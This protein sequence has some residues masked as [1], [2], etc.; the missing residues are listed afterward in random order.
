MAMT[1]PSCGTEQP[2]GARFCFAC[3]AAQGAA[4]CP[5]CGTELVPGARFC[6]G[7]GAVQ[8]S[9]AAGLSG[10]APVASRR[11]TSVLFGDLVG[12]TTLAERRDQEETRELL[13]RYFEECRRVIT[14]YGGTVEKFIGDAVMAV[15]GVPVAHEDDAERAV[16]AGLELVAVVT[17]MGEDLHIDDLSM[18]VG[19]VT[20]EVAVTIGAQQQGMVAGD[21]VNTASR[22]QSVAAPGQVWVDETTRLLTTSAI[23]YLDVGSHRLKGKADPVPLGS[24]RAVVAGVGGSQREDGLEAPLVGREHELR[25]VKEVF[26]ATDEA[27]RPKLLVMVGEP[28]V[29]KTRLAWEFEKYVDGLTMTVRWH[30]GRCVAY[31]EGI[32]FF[33]LAEAIR[34]RLRVL[35]PEDADDDPDPV[36]GIETALHSYVPD[37]EERDWLRPRLGALLGV[38]SL[39]TFPREDL[40]AAWTT[41]LER[42]GEGEDPV[43]LVIDDVHHAHDGLLQFVEHLLD[44]GR[45]PCFVLLLSRPGLLERH[46]ALATNRHATVSHVHALPDTDMA[47]LLDGLVVGLPD[48]VRDALVDRSE[49]VPLFAVET[50]RSL[51][52]RDLVVPRGGRYVLADPSSVDLDAVGAPASLQALVGARLDA[53]APEH[54]R[55]VDRASVI[56]TVFSRDEVAKLCPDIDDVDAALAALVRQQILSQQSSRFNAEYGQYQ[57]VQSVVRQVA[58]G[59]LSRRDRRALHVAVARQTAAVEDEAGELAP[60]IAQHYLDA[61]E[62]MPSEPDVDELAALAI[63]QLERAAARARALGAIPESAGHLQTALERAADPHT[64]ARLEAALA[65]AL[66]DAGQHEPAIPH[67]VTAV[68]AFD[69]L[70]D[71]IRAGSAAA[72]HG[73]ALMSSGDNA[74]AAQVVEPRWDSL[75]EMP[76]ADRA[77]LELGKI[78]HLATGRLGDVRRDVLERRIQIAERVGETEQLADALTA[79][80]TSY[81]AMGASTTARA[82]MATA[83]DLARTHHYPAALARCLSNLTVEYG[84]DDLTRALETGREGVAV[85]ARSGV[86]MWR[87][88]TEANLLLALTAAGE[89]DEVSG[90]LQRGPEGMASQVVVAGVDGWISVVRGR[91]FTVPW[92]GSPPESD[93]PSDTA[94]IAFAEGHQARAEGRLGD[95]L[96]L[97]RVAAETMAQLSAFSDDFVHLWPVAVDAAIS[98]RSEEHLDS[99]FDVFDTTSARHKVPLS[100]RAHRT[101]FASLLLRDED[102]EAAVAGLADALA[103]FSTWGS[104]PYVARTQVELGSVL[105]RTGTEEAEALLESGLATLHQLEASA[106]VRE[107]LGDPAVAS[108]APGPA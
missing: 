19:I 17:A 91:P 28:G 73:S 10:G 67:A 27:G 82:V 60:I 55:L 93:D 8:E 29:G 86:A 41:F 25:L 57:F 77:L 51:V 104:R 30:R 70:G 16:R 62:A 54:R 75:L 12:F 98:A 43:V 44:A 68:E 100:L 52:D 103:G 13:G 21:A 20:G 92:G 88:Y 48:K 5:A 7:C 107:L 65:W 49:G 22:V 56:G 9:A 47:T 63:T 33:A 46:P 15:W 18:R 79:L 42:V 38:G 106:W 23:T 97:L 108:E 59:T 66:E 95:S 32:A 102:P 11:V 6:S 35:G 101:R 31:G 53:L 85:A 24:V 71:P 61:I 2:D 58:Y 94:W 36:Q 96:R 84:L 74:G 90:M 99:L 76:G 78:L 14:R 39:G 83:A 81:S 45:F 26:H 3:G 50:V 89:W 87:D 64:R 105:R 69:V 37:E 4:A 34:G 40:F 1:C 80:S 72:A